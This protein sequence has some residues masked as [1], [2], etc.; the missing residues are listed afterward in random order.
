MN[1]SQF[2]TFKLSDVIN[3]L[4]DDKGKLIKAPGIPIKGFKEPQD[5]TQR[6]MLIPSL[7]PNYVFRGSE[8]GLIARFFL[9]KSR[10]GLWV[11]GPTGFWQ[12]FGNRA[13]L[14]PIELAGSQLYRLRQI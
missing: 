2:Q 9:K 14:C 8:L 12:D 11:S 5:G 3:N 4:V 6:K 7:I 10:Y 13:V 1:E